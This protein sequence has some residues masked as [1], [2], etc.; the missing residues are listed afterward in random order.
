M[1]IKLNVDTL[2]FALPENPFGANVRRVEK[3]TSSTKNLVEKAG[4]GSAKFK[5]AKSKI[6]QL[7]SLKKSISPAINEKIDIRALALLFSTSYAKNIEIDTTIL[8]K[9]TSIR[10]KPSLLFIE[11]LYEYFL[12][13]YDK[14][15]EKEAVQNW[16]YQ[17]KQV[18]KKLTALDEI[19]LK[20][21]GPKNLVEST[22]SSQRDFDEFVKTM[23]L[24]SYQSGRF[25]TLAQFIYYLEE[26][27]SLPVNKDSKILHEVQKR[28]VFESIYDENHLLGH[29]ILE[30]IISRAP[31]DEIS[32][33]WQH[34]IMAIAGDPRIP[35]THPK[36]VKWWSKID[37]NLRHKVIGW[38]SKLDLKLFLEALDD[39][40]KT[41]Y[42]FD[43]ERMFPSRKRFMEGLLEKKLVHGTR[44]FLTDD[45]IRYLKK[46]YNQ[47]HLPSFSRVAGDK[48]I[49]YLRVG[50]SHMIEGSHSCRLWIYDDLDDSA[51]VKNY[52]LTDFTYEDLTTGMNRRMIRKGIR[53]VAAITHAP[54]NFNWQ[55]KAIEA[56]RQIG[57]PVSPKD[58][59]LPNDYRQ[60]KAI[61]G[62]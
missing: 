34:V 26:L 25:L 32:E 11:G 54:A 22:K 29:K 24:D 59:L 41:S 36:Y 52:N 12:T 30:I 2:S 17:A 58:V 5:R 46:N 15:S 45:S 27:K 13:F 55:K 44:L 61:H 9:I 7:I 49:I 21:N 3:L 19:V 4:T 40:A 37:K 23:G 8:N 14:I 35:E 56:F 43:L 1:N 50:H 6:L 38:L 28:T 39:Y 62:A 10:S 31:E 16:L 18:R 33:S 57:V 20:G 51:V 53:E 47:E 48:S 42:N 60:Y